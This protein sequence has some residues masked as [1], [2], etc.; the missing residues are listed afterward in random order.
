[1]NPGLRNILR[2]FLNYPIRVVLGVVCL[3]M[4]DL[5]QLVIPLVV[6]EVIDRVATQTASVAWLGRISL[7]LIAIA[8][9]IALFRFIWR[10][11]FFVAARRM[12]LKL[13]QQ[14]YDH[15]LHLDAHNLSTINTGEIMALATN[16]LESVRMALAMGFVAGFDATIFAVFALSAMVWLDSSTAL[17]VV[18]PL[19]ILAVLMRFSL[20]AVYERWDGVQE[21]FGKLSERA[22]ESIA[23]VRVIKAFGQLE[24][25]QA[26]F[27]QVNREYFERYLRYSRVDSFFRPAILLLTGLCLVILLLHGGSRVIE[28]RLSIGTFVAIAT[29]LG[30][31]T[32]PM[33]AAGWMAAL[34]Q[35]AAASMERIQ[36]FLARPREPLLK[37]PVLGGSGEPAAASNSDAR[38]IHGDIE[39]QDVTF[40]YP[41]GE[42]PALENISFRVPAGASWGVVGEVGSGKSTL[43]TLL[44]GFHLPDSGKLLIDGVDLS[45]MER[46]ELRQ[47]IAWVP[48]EGFL[49]SDTIDANLRMG[50]PDA[51]FEKLHQ[52]CKQAAVMDE[53]TSFEKGFDTLLGERGITL[54]GGQ[55]QRI[56][57][58]RALLKDSP[59]L[60]LDDTLSAVDSR[61]QADIIA[62]LEPILQQRTAIVISH[63]ISA[64][65]SLDQIL[66]LRRGRIVQ[67]GSHQQLM[68]QAGYYREMSQLQELEC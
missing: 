5:G 44:L 61:T 68:A 25:D 43:A 16:D 9:G 40:S 30:M 65:R 54:S 1:M 39:F 64:V 52:V 60:L 67:Q 55:K 28:G 15:A 46:Q 21:T 31:L 12:E 34:L 18:L 45:Q 11:L 23:G 51:A 58:A 38:V 8:L 26:R 13:R 20:K 62:A 14:I 29:Y 7:V 53:I 6:R 33:I 32:W 50:D 42:Q 63:R 19:P 22:R 4:V 56:C 59:I 36:R 48:Q 10:H 27:D 49:F 37:S 66:V 47:A 41:A 2:L 17:W 3:L 24:C 57:L 35:R